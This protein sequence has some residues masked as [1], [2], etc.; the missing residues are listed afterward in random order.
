M[1]EVDLLRAPGFG[2]GRTVVHGFTARRGGSW[3]AP[4]G[5]T[6]ARAEGVP[7]AC[8]A[9]HWTRALH[10][11]DPRLEPARLALASQ[12]HGARVIRV[13]APT[14]PL[15][16]AGEADALV[17]TVPGLALA[18]RIADC[19]PVLLATD[20]GVAAV[21]A[22]WRGVVAGVVGAAVD[23]LREAT[24]ASDVEAAVGPH[25]GVDAF[26]V[27]PEVVEALEAAGLPRADVAHPGRRDRW[28]VDLGRAVGLQ[29]ADAGAA[30]VA[31][32]GG[33]TW[34]PRFFSWRREGPAAGRQAGIVAWQP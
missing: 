32:T 27:G 18:V 10:A 4:D 1:A 12:V 8:L 30:R 7:D 25:L 22:G 9:D 26:E 20:G 14:G 15:A 2:D 16:T 33:S 5:L 31:R 29:L 11:V 21:H 24:G 3:P 34:D 6:L 23:A 28:Q 17:T 13:E 19:V